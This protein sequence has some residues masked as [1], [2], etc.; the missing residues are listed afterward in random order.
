MTRFHRRVCPEEF[1][2]RNSSYDSDLVTWYKLFRLFSDRQSDSQEYLVSK[3]RLTGAPTV[4]KLRQRKRLRGQRL[5]PPIPENEHIAV[6]NVR[7]VRVRHSVRVKVFSVIYY[8]GN[9]FQ[10]GPA[11]FNCTD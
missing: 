10:G 2:S 3:D 8:D 7:N 9:P 1:L 11:S 6:M 5:V 4:H